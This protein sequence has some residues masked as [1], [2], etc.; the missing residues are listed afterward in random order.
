MGIKGQKGKSEMFGFA[1]RPIASSGKKGG[2]FGV[3]SVFKK[4]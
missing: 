2:K 1:F 4:R 3:S